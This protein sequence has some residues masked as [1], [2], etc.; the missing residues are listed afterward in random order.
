LLLHALVERAQRLLMRGYHV[1][2]LGKQPCLQAADESSLNRISRARV[3][4]QIVLMYLGAR[5]SMVVMLAMPIDPPM[6]RIKL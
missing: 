4:R 1:C 6:L 3:G 2:T 5:T